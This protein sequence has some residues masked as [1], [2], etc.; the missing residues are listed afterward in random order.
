MIKF[1]L[2]ILVL[3]PAV[4]SL[5]E[6]IFGSIWKKSQ[7]T[8]SIAVNVLLT[9]MTIA[10]MYTP[11]LNPA[12]DNTS[13]VGLVLVSLI[14][15]FV[16]IGTIR[17][18]NENKLYYPCL[19]ITEALVIG[20]LLSQGLTMLKLVLWEAIWI[21]VFI[22]LITSKEKLLSISFFKVWFLSETL[23]ISSFILYQSKADIHIIFWLMMS[24]VMIRMFSFPFDSLIKRSV[25]TADFSISS[26]IGVILPVLPIFFVIQI[27]IPNFGGELNFFYDIISWI[28]ISGILAWII[29]LAIDTT[30]D[31][32][33]SSQ[34]I[35]FNSMIGIWL[36]HPSGNLLF[37]VFQII[38]IKT[39][40]NILIVYYGDKTKLNSRSWLF[41][42][43]VIM[44]FGIPGIIIGAPL[45]HLTSAWY[46]IDPVI[47]ITTL[48]LFT[49]CFIYSSIVITP[50]FISS[51]KI[52]INLRTTLLILLFVFTIIVSLVSNRG[53]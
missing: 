48:V 9:A 52:K 15:L 18:I 50:L 43:P 14:F 8:I 10:V 44:S 45:L 36:T 21:P 4:C 34:I 20:F 2:L 27:M 31:D 28:F 3:V 53:Y 47:C 49:L 26:I 24:G 7:G 42:I 11:G 25:N 22:I 41:T 46:G 6:F 38:F 13:S 51:P 33:V 12:I 40:I 17:T 23:I 30:I 19:L 29:R 35:I 16:S 1:D 32:V 5:L 39:L 37:A